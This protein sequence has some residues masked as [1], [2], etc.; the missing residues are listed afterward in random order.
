MTNFLR[1]VNFV[2]KWNFVS[3]PWKIVI[4]RENIVE[5]HIW[6]IQIHLGG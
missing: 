6:V 3:T 5:D 2:E 4:P 1:C